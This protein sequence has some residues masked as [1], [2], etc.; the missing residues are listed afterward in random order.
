MFADGDMIPS[1]RAEIVSHGRDINTFMAY[2]S[3]LFR[4]VGTLENSS[5][6][7]LRQNIS[8]IERNQITQTDKVS[9][10][11]ANITTLWANTSTLA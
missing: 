3:D 11:E 10:F 4:R 8:A 1:I 6:S 7:S 2:S 5:M 9:S